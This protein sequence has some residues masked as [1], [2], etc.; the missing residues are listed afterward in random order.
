MKRIIWKA[1]AAIVVLCCVLFS[2]TACGETSETTTQSGSDEQAQES[3]GQQTPAANTCTV[4]F[5]TQGGSEVATQQ[6][7]KGDRVQKPQDPERAGYAFAGWTYSGEDWSF[8][9]HTVTGNMTLTAIWEPLLNV[10]ETGTIQN[11]T[12]CGKTATVIDIPSVY[13][14]IAIT[15]IGPR[16]FYGC[17][18]LTSITIPDSVTSIGEYAFWD[19]TGLTSITA[20]TGN[21]VY[22]SVDNCLIK[23]AEKTLVL[24]CKTST[25]PT[26]GSV[27]SIGNSAFAGCTGLT[28]ITIPDSVTNIGQYALCNCKNLTSITY[29]GTKAQWNAISKGYCWNIDADNYVMHCTDGDI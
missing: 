13:N 12:D 7:E 10:S 8:I 6:V 1:V 21:A 3:N 19:C 17:T 11:L 2:L 29:Q 26:D 16:A 24:G 4:T 27:T 23:T 22:H 28:S 18:G 25:I 9:Q 5:D 20:A 14:G 15:S